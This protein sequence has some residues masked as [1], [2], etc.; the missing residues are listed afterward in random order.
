MAL[1]RAARTVL[2]GVIIWAHSTSLLVWFWVLWLKN[3]NEL[4]RG[5]ASVSNRKVS[6]ESAAQQRDQSSQRPQEQ[7]P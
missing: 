4:F 2:A 1:Q 3:E 6:R 5:I 7:S